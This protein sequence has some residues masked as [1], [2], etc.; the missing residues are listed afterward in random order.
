MTLNEVTTKF[1]GKT[2]VIPPRAARQVSR[3]Y[4]RHLF[5]ARHLIENFFAKLKHFRAIATRYDKTKRNFLAAIQ[6]VAAVKI[7]LTEKA[8]LG[9]R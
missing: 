3:D 6:L 1:A 8:R 4:D 9:R 5:K 7:G 2:A